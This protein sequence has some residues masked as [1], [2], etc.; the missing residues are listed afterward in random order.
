M[1]ENE[2]AED[3][4]HEG[5]GAA[6]GEEFVDPELE[7]AVERELGGEDFVLGEDEEENA[8]GNAEEGEGAGVLIF[9]GGI[10]E[11]IEGK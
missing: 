9:H 6:F 5:I 3:G 4:G 1:G 8:D 7:A 2:I 11:E 10:I